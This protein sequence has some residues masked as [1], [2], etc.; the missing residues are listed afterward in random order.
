MSLGK[1]LFMR[2]KYFLE[3]NIFINILKMYFLIVLSL[4]RMIIYLFIYDD[5]KCRNQ[6]NRVFI[7]DKKMSYSMQGFYMFI[8]IAIGNPICRLTIF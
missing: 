1:L 4:R 7:G 5:N 2:E 3:K 6:L 8:S